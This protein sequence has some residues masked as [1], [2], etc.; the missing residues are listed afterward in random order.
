[1]AERLLGRGYEIRKGGERDERR[2]KG[3]MILFCLWLQ[4]II[5]LKRRAR[6][7]KKAE[8]FANL[9]LTNPNLGNYFV[10]QTSL[11]PNDELFF[12]EKNDPW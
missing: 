12:K 6:E 7:K 5:N 10:Y 11:I 3:G 2:G 8:R 4:D 1:M 9:H